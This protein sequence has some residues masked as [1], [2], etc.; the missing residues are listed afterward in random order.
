MKRKIA[1]LAALALTTSGLLAQELSGRLARIKDQ[2]TIVLSYSETGVPF[3]YVGKNGPIGFGPD[4]S[5]KVVEGVQAHLGL[6][7]LKI[8]WNA[9]TLSTRFPMIVTNTVDVECVSTTNTR[10]RQEMVAFSNTFYVS[11]EGMAVRRE[12]GIRGYADLAGKRVATVRGTPTESALAAKGF[13]VVAERNNRSAM[14]A[15]VQGRADAYVASASIIAGELLR[16]EDASALQVIASGGNQ[17]AFACMLPK[18]DAA[19]K[20][21]VDNTLEKIMKSGEME[22]LYDKWF[23]RPIAPFDRNVSMPLNEA[24]RQLYL[25]PNDLAL[26]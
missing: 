13:T 20:K 26:E 24:S 16:L 14:A 25:A 10:K 22:A 12:S 8:R 5:R 4:I 18:G 17:E 21:V 15:L 2:G 6:P 7:E 1:L 19:F 11:D 9:V 3:S 23:M